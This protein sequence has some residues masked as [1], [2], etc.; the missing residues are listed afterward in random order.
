[1]IK[2]GEEGP[3][4]LTDQARQALERGGVDWGAAEATTTS[5]PTFDV[6]AKVGS[7]ATEVT[8]QQ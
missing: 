8:Q 6:P 4:P 3:D 7:M 1:M 2:Q 5:E